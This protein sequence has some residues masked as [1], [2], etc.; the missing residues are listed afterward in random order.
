MT[1]VPLFDLKFQTEFLRMLEELQIGGTSGAALWPATPHGLLLGGRTDH[2]LVPSAFSCTPGQ[3]QRH[4]N[5]VVV[6]GV[7]HEA[8][9]RGRP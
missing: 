7:F 1:L 2:L 3:K 8:Q 6:L 4:L 9:E 5:Q